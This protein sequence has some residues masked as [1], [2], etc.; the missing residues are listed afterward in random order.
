MTPIILA[1]G[2]G[3]RLG[4]AGA[5]RPKC[6][7]PVAGETLLSRALARI[8]RAGFRRAAVVVGFRSDRVRA[9][10]ASLATRLEVRFVEN[11]RYETTNNLYSLALG[12]EA[13]GGGV[14]VINGD[15]YFH[16]DLLRRLGDEPGD[17]AAVVD[18]KRPLAGD[19]MRTQVVGTEITC[20]GKSLP[21]DLADGNAIGLYRFSGA[22]ADALRAE[23]ARWVSDGRLDAFY[24]EAVS[25][26]A[27]TISI[28]AVSTGGLTWGEIDDPHD[29]AAAPGRIARMLAEEDLAAAAVAGAGAGPA[30]AGWLPVLARPAAGLGAA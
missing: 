20:L 10:V 3:R 13:I 6:L 15:D 30:R 26:L 8:E 24:V 2:R 22:A 19:A 4:A 29:L 17:A 1:A 12:L 27:K 7:V 21:A 14:T 28:R 16:G 9:H 11:P 5:Q 25:A 18:F 23:V